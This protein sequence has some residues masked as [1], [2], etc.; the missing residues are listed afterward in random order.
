MAPYRL[1]RA[2]AMASRT[3]RYNKMGSLL[4]VLFPSLSLLSTELS[5]AKANSRPV[6]KQKRDL[7]QG[8]AFLAG[9]LPPVRFVLVVIVITPNIGRYQLPPSLEQVTG[10]D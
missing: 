8:D 3:N 6:G 4:A 9:F 7:T 1:Q 2:A 5:Y 10:L